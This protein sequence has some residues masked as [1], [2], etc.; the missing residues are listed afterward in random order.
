MTFDL[1][2]SL[3]VLLLHCEWSQLDTQATVG[4]SGGW[5]W[6]AGRLAGSRVK[7]EG[8]EPPEEG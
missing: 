7:A 8:E 4:W 6:M 5:D 1:P 3:S 2:D